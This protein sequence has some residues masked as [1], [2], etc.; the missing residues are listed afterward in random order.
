MIG[1]GLLGCGRIGRVHA[2]N[3]GAHPRA[4]LV[5]AYDP[6]GTAAETVAA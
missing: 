5:A 2:R 3:I 4:R 6:M 1:I